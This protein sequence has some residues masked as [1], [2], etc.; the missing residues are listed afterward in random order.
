MLLVGLGVA[1]A[2]ALGGNGNGVQ[3]PE[4]ASAAASEGGV[5]DNVLVD[6]EPASSVAG[7]QLTEESSDGESPLG[8]VVDEADVS[9]SSSVAQRI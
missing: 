6:D 3:T 2:T 7:D 9:A 5:L 1:G 4:T 8:P